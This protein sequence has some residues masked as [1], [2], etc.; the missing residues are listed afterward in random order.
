MREKQTNKQ[1]HLRDNLMKEETD[2]RRYLME[3]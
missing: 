2:E 3:E 1:K